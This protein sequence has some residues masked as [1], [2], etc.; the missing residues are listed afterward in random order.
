VILS[1]GTFNTPQILMLSGIGP[2]KELLKH[3]IKP[4]LDLPGVG[5]NL[6]D[7]YEITVVNRLKS[8]FK[9]WDHA[10][11][12]PEK[13]E[14]DVWFEEWKKNRKGFYT[15]SGATLAFVKRS[16]PDMAEPDLFVFGTP[17]YFKGYYPNYQEDVLT[18]G[19]GRRSPDVFTWAILKK[20]PSTQKRGSVTLENDDPFNQPKIQFNYFPD[21]QNDEVDADALALANGI[22]FVRS[23]AGESTKAHEQ[24]YSELQPGIDKTSDA[25]LAQWVRNEAWGHHACGTCRMGSDDEKEGQE[26]RTPHVVD[27]KFRVRYVKGLRIVD[28]SVFPDIPGYFI[29]VPIYMIAEKAAQDILESG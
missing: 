19:S 9:F 23:L 28:A 17:V 10:Y 22:R 7:R 24:I 5:Q 2:E 16:S 8:S 21:S 18:D 26:G 1:A 15:N 29:A 20:S 4:L 12:D 27:S 6:H 14:P 25:D 11:L 13:T 3:G